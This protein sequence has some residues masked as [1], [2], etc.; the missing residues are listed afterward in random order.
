MV[1]KTNVEYVFIF[2]GL[3]N[4][5]LLLVN[6]FKVGSKSDIMLINL[7]LLPYFICVNLSNIP[8]RSY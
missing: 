4:P 2:Q 7:L 1:A 8:N 3:R 5:W 6:L